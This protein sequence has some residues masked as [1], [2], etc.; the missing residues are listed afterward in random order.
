MKSPFLHMIDPASVLAAARRLQTVAPATRLGG[1]HAAAKKRARDEFDPEVDDILAEIEARQSDEGDFDA[2][3]E[4]IANS[5]DALPADEGDE[6]AAQAPDAPAWP[7]ADPAP[8]KRTSTAQAV[9][10][11][12]GE[13]GEDSGITAADGDPL[14]DAAGIDEDEGDDLPGDLSNLVDTSD[15]EDADPDAPG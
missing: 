8:P 9:E 2:F 3:L 4:R 1:R 5:A 13:D 10:E 15:L 14:C 6:D 12:P 7:P 11:L